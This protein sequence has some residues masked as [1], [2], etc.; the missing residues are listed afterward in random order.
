MAVLAWPF[1]Y[2]GLRVGPNAPLFVVLA[3]TAAR[4][5]AVTRVETL[6]CKDISETNSVKMHCSLDHLINY[7]F[8][9][10]LIKLTSIRILNDM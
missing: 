4:V 9:S 7:R 3:A 1:L 8:I 6:E 5:S 10:I 2:Y